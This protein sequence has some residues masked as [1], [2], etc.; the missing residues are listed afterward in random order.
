MS[1]AIPHAP[2]GS[3]CQ[4]V[5]YLPKSRN[6]VAARP[7]SKINGVRAAFERPV[8]FYLKFSDR[9]REALQHKYVQESADP[10][11]HHILTDVRRCEWRHL[12]TIFRLGSRRPVS[13]GRKKH[14]AV[15][16]RR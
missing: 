7:V 10:V 12:N 13:Y 2:A 11:D 9:Q 6:H 1:R 4:I 3:R 5:M 14:E 15:A 16:A 8:A